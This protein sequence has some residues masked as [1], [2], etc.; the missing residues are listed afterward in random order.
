MPCAISILMLWSPFLGQ[1]HIKLHKTW[2]TDSFPNLSGPTI[3]AVNDSTICSGF[4]EDSDRTNWPACLGFQ[5]A[6]SLP[7][8]VHQTLSM[9]PSLP[10]SSL[11]HSSLFSL[12]FSS[13]RFSSFLFLSLPRAFQDAYPI[14][15]RYGNTHVHTEH[16]QFSPWHSE[17][18]SRRFISA[19][20]HA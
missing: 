4:C 5:F 6:T 12:P 19:G 11:L 18:S 20:C 14:A 1:L 15:S 9:F 3:C 13:F 10:L 7:Q 2:K 8:C 16:V 17:I